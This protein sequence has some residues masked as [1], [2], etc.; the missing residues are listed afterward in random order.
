MKARQVNASK[1]PDSRP[2]SRANSSTVLK[3]V[4]C[5]CCGGM[6]HY[7]DKCK[8]KADSYCNTCKSTGHYDKMCQRRG[9]TKRLRSADRS[10]SR[11]KRRSYS[12]N[13]GGRSPGRG[14]RRKQTPKKDFSQ[15]T[16]L[17]KGQDLRLMNQSDK[18]LHLENAA[19]E[20]GAQTEIEEEVDQEEM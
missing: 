18:D 17:M 4:Q 9:G 6:G 20:E 15:L 8:K 1:K 11:E 19:P 13:G 7:S 3:H 5:Y 2:N 10:K 16:E 14:Y 12:R